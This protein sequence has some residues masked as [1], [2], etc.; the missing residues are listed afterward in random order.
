MRKE[1]LQP[2]QGVLCD[3]ALLQPVQESLCDGAQL[4]LI[5]SSPLRPF[6]SEDESSLEIKKSLQIRL[7]IVC[8][9]EVISKHGHDFCRHARSGHAMTVFTQMVKGGS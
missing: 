6:S 2:V 5:P 8:F 9:F 7:F 1:S 4:H 3:G